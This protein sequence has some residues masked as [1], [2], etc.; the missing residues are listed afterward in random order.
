MC[1][2]NLHQK[3]VHAAQLCNTD[4]VSKTAKPR[5]KE[6]FCFH[7]SLDFISVFFYEFLEYLIHCIIHNSTNILLD[8]ITLTVLDK[9]HK[10]QGRYLASGNIKLSLELN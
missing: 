3:A 9:K 10:F 1:D 4:V 5:E 8:L 7:L 6:Q 2:N